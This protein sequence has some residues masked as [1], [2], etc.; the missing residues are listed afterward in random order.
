M[1]HA[2]DSE[3]R[4]AV[5]D[6][7]SR[8]TGVPFDTGGVHL[9]ARD[10]AASVHIPY[11]LPAR[12]FSAGIFPPVFGEPLVSSC[13]T[14]GGWLLIDFYDSFY[15]TLVD[16]VRAVLPAVGCETESHAIN[17]LGSLARHGSTGCPRV[18]SFQRALL[19]ALSAQN[20][21]GAYA[22]A[23]RAC[24]T[25]LQP[26]PPRERPALIRQSGALG[27]ALARLLFSAKIK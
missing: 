13:R 6:A 7:L 16:R 26:V 22:R 10:S 18:P 21:P 23:D 4:S 1:S 24:E 3:I 9:P 27:D 15:D 12:G 11:L 2:L 5:A 25:M 14:L 17:K 8:E 19:F 20:G